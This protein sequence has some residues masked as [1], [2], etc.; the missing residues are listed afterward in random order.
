[1]ATDYLVGSSPTP[2]YPPPPAMPVGRPYEAPPPP[3][4]P[5]VQ[6]FAKGGRVT[7]PTLAMLGEAGEAEWVIPESK[8][9]GTTVII[10]AQNSI[11]ESDAALQRLADK[12]AASMGSRFGQGVRV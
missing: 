12:V 8:M 4:T 9:G 7:R 2:S 3:A 10:N 6:P 11:F 5:Q 1:M